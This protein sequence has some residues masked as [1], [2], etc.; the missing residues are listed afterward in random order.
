MKQISNLKK[1]M[2]IWLG[3]KIAKTLRQKGSYI[4]SE[5]ALITCLLPLSIPKR[6]EAR[7]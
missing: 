4:M 5:N 2:A 3:E 1:H 7:F 6:H